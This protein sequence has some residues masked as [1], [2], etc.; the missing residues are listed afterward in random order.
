[1]Q[2]DLVETNKKH[3]DGKQIKLIKT[4]IAQ[5]CNDAE[6]ALFINVCERTGLDPFSRQIYAIK[7]FD[8]ASGGKKMVIQ[9]GVDGYRLIA[10]RTGKYAGNSEAVYEYDANGGLRK[11]TVTVL[12]MLN[13]VSCP[14]TSSA[15]MAEY[16]PSSPGPLWKR[17]PHVMLGKCAEV[18]A[19]RKAFPADLSGLYTT[20]EMHQADESGLAERPREDL[21]PAPSDPAG[22]SRNQLTEI[23]A[24]LKHLDMSADQRAEWARSVK[25]AF[26]VASPKELTSEQAAKV[27]YEL[28]AVRNNPFA[29]QEQNGEV[30]HAEA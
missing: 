25:E 8:S 16:M 9:T 28:H 14:F 10:E 15:L 29:K 3:F 19:L 20:E 21:L 5:D 22:V 6:L 1:M 17:M 23:N 30:E 24:L 12:K 11:A 13:G 26:H 2:T 27:I 4:Q 18:A 7:R